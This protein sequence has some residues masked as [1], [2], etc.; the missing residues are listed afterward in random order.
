MRRTPGA[1]FHGNA[2]VF[3][4]DYR[5]WILGHFVRPEEHPLHSQD[6]EVKWTTHAAGE[7]RPEWSPAAPVRTLNLLIRGRFAVLFPG[8][9]VVLER[10]GDFV[11]FGPGIAHS[12]RA[13]EESL[14]MAIRWPSRPG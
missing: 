3:A 12:F 9:E 14:V 7:T 6:V 13:I 8:E 2:T 10:E 5:G 11:V 4:R 1:P